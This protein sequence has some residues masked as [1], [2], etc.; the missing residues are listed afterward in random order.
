MTPDQVVDT[1]ALTGD[2]VDNVKGVPGIGLKTAVA[3]LQQFGTV[4]GILANLD[5]VSG[6][7]RKQNLDEH[8]KTLE[9]AR[10]LITL[11]TDLP[12][13]LDWDALKSDGYDAPALRALA[14]LPGRPSR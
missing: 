14:T 4:D 5:K 13:E 1:L 2:S 12:L 6:A 3:L 7:K 10:E 9:V 8:R 11:E